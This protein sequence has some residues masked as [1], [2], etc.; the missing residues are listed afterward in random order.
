ML[1]SFG[2]DEVMFRIAPALSSQALGARDI[3]VGL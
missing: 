1:G 3:V 2:K